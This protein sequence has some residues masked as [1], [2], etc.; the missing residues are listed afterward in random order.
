MNLTRRNWVARA[1]ALAASSFGGAAF[2][3]GRGIKVSLWDTGAM[4]LHTDGQGPMMGMAMSATGQ[5]LPMA[6]MG[7]K[8]SSHTVAAGL[9]SF[10]VR[11]DSKVLAHEMVVSRI[12]NAKMPLPFKQGDNKVDE[13]AAGALGEV[14]EL[15][16]GKSG[17]L[18]LTL[19][20]GQYILY[21]NVVGHY[22]HGMWTILTVT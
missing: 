8:L 10:N 13:D 19:K 12:N 21:C 2:A 3:T 1:V 9:V 16:P 18:K 15:E 11:N 4:A 22:A 17:A 6:H 14:A 5:R 20:R 7:I